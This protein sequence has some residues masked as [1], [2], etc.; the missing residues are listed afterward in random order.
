[1]FL[2]RQSS[3]PGKAAFYLLIVGLLGSINVAHAAGDLNPIPK[4]ENNWQFSITPYAWLPGIHATANFPNGA[5]KSAAFNSSNVL[6]GI[7]TGG[8][9][10]GEARYGKWGVMVD[11][12]SATLQKSNSTP[13]V[14]RN[15]AAVTIAEKATV[16]QTIMTGSASY[17][18][19][20][21]SQMNVDG[22]LGVR[23]VF[24]TTTLNLT[25]DG[26]SRSTSPYQAS[27]SLYPILGA[28]GRYRLSDSSWYIPVSADIGTGASA[29]TMTWQGLVGVGNAIT[30]A[31]DV[32]LAYRALYYSI[33]EDGV[34]Q[35][36]TMF[37][38]QLSL[39]INF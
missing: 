13:V 2:I 26:T 15:S 22:L 29:N 18:L 37:G 36:S 20:T 1:M 35:K 27:S 8:M 17:N 14:L 16:Q 39:S 11:F 19:L 12:L 25:L 24:M 3:L 5:A 21:N 38:P 9:I 34:K 30:P 28:K 31:I 10:A 7:K 6:S 33:Q 32:L 4:I 23:G